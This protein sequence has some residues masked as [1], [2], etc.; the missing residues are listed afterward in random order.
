MEEVHPTMNTK[1]SSCWR[2]RINIVGT[3]NLKSMEVKVMRFQTVNGDSIFEYF[4]FLKEKY[5]KKICGI[6]F[7]LCCRSEL[8]VR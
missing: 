7:V 8:H 3:I 4:D 5:P 2:T 6:C 1:A